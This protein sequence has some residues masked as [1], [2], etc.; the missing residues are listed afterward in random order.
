MADR[1]IFV[2]VIVRFFDWCG[3]ASDCLVERVIG[4]LNVRRE[5]PRESRV[6][7][8]SQIDLATAAVLAAC[9]RMPR[10]YSAA[11][12]AFRSANSIPTGTPL[13]S[14]IG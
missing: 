9:A 5:T 7:M 11:R 8:A 4:V 3:S 10:M 6:L 12:R 13:T 1:A 2:R 14:G